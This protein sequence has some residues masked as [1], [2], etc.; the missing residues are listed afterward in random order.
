FVFKFG[1]GK[2]KLE[3]QVYNAIIPVIDGLAA[4]IE[5]SI[6]FFQGRYPSLKLERIVVTGGASVLPEFPLYLAN[7][8]GINVEI[9]NSW[10][11]VLVPPDRQ[12][13]AASV[14]NQFAIAAGLAERES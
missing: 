3:G 9:G 1:L 11:N 8:F 14:S 6:K 13:D 5:K 10:R 12:N 2:D 4:E 7:R